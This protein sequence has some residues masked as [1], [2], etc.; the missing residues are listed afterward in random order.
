ML[1][2]YWCSS[3]QLWSGCVTLGTSNLGLCYVYLPHVWII[4][5][6]FWVCQDVILSHFFNKPSQTISRIQCRFICW[7]LKYGMLSFRLYMVVLLE[8]LIAWERWSFCSLSFSLSR[9]IFPL[10]WNYLLPCVILCI[11]EIIHQGR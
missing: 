2:F 7:T 10:F 6:V 11:H 3:K 9:T 1:I 4:L 5:L 8:H